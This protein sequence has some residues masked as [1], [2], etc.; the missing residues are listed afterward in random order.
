VLLALTTPGVRGSTGAFITIARALTSHGHRVTLL[1]GHPE[2]ADALAQSECPVH[3]VPTGDTAPREVAA[4]RRLFRDTANE[5]VL[6]DAP[7]DV[8]I[9]RYASLGRRR[10]IIWRYNLH[11][12]RLATD[13]LQRWLF[14][15]VAHVV[16]QSA[17]SVRLLASDSPW[18]RRPSSV[19]PNGFDLAAFPLDAARAQAFRAGLGIDR[20]IPLVV[21][22]TAGIAGKSLEVA[23]AAMRIVGAERHVT[24]AHLGSEGTHATGTL[25]VMAL[26]RIG[27]ARLL[28]A[29]RAADVVLLPSTR[30]LFGNVTAEAMALARPV[31]AANSGAT[32]ELVGEAGILAAA[33]DAV[34]MARGI[35]ALL[36]A[37]ER[38]AALG[39]AAR[40]RIAS[41]FSLAAMGEAYD[42]LVRQVR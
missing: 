20:E 35:A 15:G 34:A 4:V 24:W 7:R 27:H 2:V 10:P 1:A 14:G 29:L 23:E 39:A 5:V 17:H 28:D 16:H 26:G 13:V 37:P 18:L 42:R 9:A 21:T 12:R 8:R 31:V 38:A 36:D 32:P 3:L 40:A 11:S 30:E 41:H 22:P 25:S 6:A 33:G 19:I